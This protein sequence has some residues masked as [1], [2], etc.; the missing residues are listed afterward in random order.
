M[1]KLFLIVSVF[2]VGLGMLLA[3]V[4][5]TF[6]IEGAIVKIWAKG[7]GTA[8]GMH[9]DP[10]V[11]TVKKD[12]VVVWMNGVEDKEIQIVFEAGEA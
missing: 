4:E 9:A 1:K 2:A 11:L 3:S 8:K 6:A 10:P 12:T 7:E 5:N